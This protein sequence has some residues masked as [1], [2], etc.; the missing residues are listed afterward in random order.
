VNQPRVQDT[1]IIVRQALSDV[2]KSPDMGVG[3]LTDVI[4][5]SSEG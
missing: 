5:V 2:A 3:L 1:G 4:N